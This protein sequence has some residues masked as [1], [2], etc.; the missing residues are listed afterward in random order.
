ML[1]GGIGFQNS[2]TV[3]GYTELRATLAC[4]ACDL[5]AT[6]KVCGF[7]NF[8]STFGSSKCMKQFVTSSFGCKPLYGGFDCNMWSVRDIVMHKQKAM[9]CKHASKTL[10]KTRLWG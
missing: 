2:S 4:I 5:P 8:N 7:A 9:E 3:M 1:Y 6:R 10:K